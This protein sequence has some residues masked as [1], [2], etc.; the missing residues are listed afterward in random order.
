M[1]CELHTGWVLGV[2][3]G[4]PFIFKSLVWSKDIQSTDTGEQEGEH[5]QGVHGDTVA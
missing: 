3:F 5:A 2:G 4:D 1:K